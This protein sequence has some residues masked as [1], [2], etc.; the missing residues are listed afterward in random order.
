MNKKNLPDNGHAI[1]YAK[2]SLVEEDAIDDGAFFFARERAWT[3]R[4]LA[5]NFRLR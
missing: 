1:R 3:I 4:D 2:P 5:G